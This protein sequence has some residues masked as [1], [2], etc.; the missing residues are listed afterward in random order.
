MN[1]FLQQPAFLK[2]QQPQQQQQQQ[3]LTLSHTQLLNMISSASDRHYQQ[4]ETTLLCTTGQ[5]SS[6][7]IPNA[8][9]KDS[10]FNTPASDASIKDDVENDAVVE[11]GNEAFSRISHQYLSCV[12]GE[13]MNDN[14]YASRHSVEA[15]ASQQ[16]RAIAAASTDMRSPQ[17]VQKK[18][19]CFEHP[20][21]LLFSQS[22]FSL[23]QRFSVNAC[24]RQ[25]T[26]SKGCVQPHLQ[27]Q[28][29]Y[30][31]EKSTCGETRGH[32]MGTG[33]SISLRMCAI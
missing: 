16:K 33:L 25:K 30:M 23:S 24:S 18:Q 8:A 6:C 1:V 3:K 21:D 15:G 2:Q 14:P 32:H 11:D 5:P 10:E 7:T 19:R 26:A 9:E 4:Q 28:D 22:D 17:R 13:Q 31:E 12:A 29:I 27:Y 20:G